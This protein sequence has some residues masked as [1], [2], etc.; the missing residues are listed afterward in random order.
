MLR[1]VLDAYHHAVEGI[2]E[3]DGIMGYPEFAKQMGELM[4][5]PGRLS[6]FDEVFEA[7]G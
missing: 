3:T 4:K 2:S 1:E 5:K 7:K 6:S